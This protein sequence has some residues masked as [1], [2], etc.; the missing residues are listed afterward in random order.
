[1]LT[2]CRL[3]KQINRDQSSTTQDLED[4]MGEGAKLFCGKYVLEITTYDTVTH[5]LESVDW[6]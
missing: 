5:Y 4:T 2:N 3:D 6:H 1:M